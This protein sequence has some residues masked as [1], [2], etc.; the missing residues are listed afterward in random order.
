MGVRSSHHPP[1]PHWDSGVLPTPSSCPLLMVGW[2]WQEE[3]VIF[4][5]L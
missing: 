1:G 2:L 5:G 4:W 3:N